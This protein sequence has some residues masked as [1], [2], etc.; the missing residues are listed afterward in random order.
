MK[1]KPSVLLIGA[2]KFGTNHLRVLKELENENK[3]MIK[4]VV[5]ATEESRK[6][7]EMNYEVKSYCGL[8]SSLLE[9]IDAI[10]IVTPASTHYDLTK[11]CIPHA[12]V[13][14]EK[15]LA[16]YSNHIKELMK[17]SANESKML[18]VGHIF[19][20][21]NALNKIKKILNEKT[22]NKEK[23]YSIE[24]KFIGGELSKDCGVLHNF[25]HM[26]DIMNDLF[27]QSPES[28][29]CT[30]LYDEYSKFE[31]YAKTNLYYR[32]LNL[33]AKIE[34]GAGELKKER[35]LNLKFKTEEI[36]CDIITQKVEVHSDCGPIKYDY[37]TK[38]P[39]KLELERFIDIITGSNEF[40]PNAKH[41]IEVQQIIDAAK[42]SA[43]TNKMIYL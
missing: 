8:S 22:E 23:L 11:K 2:G 24:G 3:L 5:T 26:F 36:F 13:L 39:L 43:K 18:M 29:Y 34:L 20:F 32:N 31:K 42:E 12:N 33:D 30:L 25:M 7:I 10:D 38:E 41:A 35:S 21:N 14:C 37:Y 4:G 15:P 16:L 6:K 19:R 40:Y 9:S 27:D 1:N 28:V 17:L